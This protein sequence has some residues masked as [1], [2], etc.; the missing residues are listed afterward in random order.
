MKLTPK[1][2]SRLTTIFLSGIALAGML[3]VSA[4]AETTASNLV[5]KAR[6]QIGVT[7]GYDP[8][9]QKLPY[10]GGDVP[11]QTGVCSDVVIRAFRKLGL[12]LQKEV[13]EDMTNAFAEYPQKWGLKKPDS[14]I[15]HRRVPNL[16]TFFQRR[17]WAVNASAKS[18]DFA[19]G[20][21]VAWDLGSGVTHIGLVSDRQTP[22]ATPLILHNIGSG[23]KEEDILLRYKIIGHYRPV[24]SSRSDST[25]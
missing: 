24:F 9:Y 10:P 8:S 4:S 19:P 20:D 22:Q 25:H 18:T 1:F 7:T 3:Y 14:N 2:F 17:G 12:D 21:I 13:H 11:A 16:M 6:E 23:T 15:D 5:S